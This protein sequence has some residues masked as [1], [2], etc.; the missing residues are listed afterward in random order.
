MQNT[1]YKY[2]VR[3]GADGLPDGTPFPSYDFSSVEECEKDL[4]E[5]LDEQ[6]WQTEGFIVGDDGSAVRFEYNGGAQT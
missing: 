5:I 6:G 2:E 1:L 4:K 3:S